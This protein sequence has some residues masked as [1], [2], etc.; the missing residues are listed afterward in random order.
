MMGLPRSPKLMRVLVAAGIKIDVPKSEPLPP[1]TVIADFEVPMRPVPWSAPHVNTNG[2][3]FKNPRLR[4]W[5]AEVSRCAA[6]AMVGRR[7]YG[8]AVK[9][10]AEFYLSPR[11]GSPPDTSNLTKS[12]EDA[13]QG[14]VI[15]NDRCVVRV[16]SERFLRCSRDC[17]WV[18]VIAV[19]DQ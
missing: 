2:P 5:Q 16:E 1:G 10:V 11:G 8:G 6:E 9:L 7:P 3:A 17:A 13:C 15:V 12:L 14:H 19:E 18:R 4:A